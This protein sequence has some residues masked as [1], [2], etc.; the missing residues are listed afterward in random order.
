[1]GIYRTA[2]GRPLDM[3]SLAAKNE[4]TRAV[5]NMNVNARGDTIDSHGKVIT[6][7]TRKVGNRYNNSVA[8]PESNRA[9]STVRP[10]TEASP[11]VDT[12]PAK[13]AEAEPVES[14]FDEM[15]DE[16]LEFLEPS[17]EDLEIEKIKKAETAKKK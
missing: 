11:E 9:R 7:V 6:P 4:K 5:G 10:K 2:Q 14:I 8:N 1:M 12:T 17:D 16:D 15:T 3:A 13:V